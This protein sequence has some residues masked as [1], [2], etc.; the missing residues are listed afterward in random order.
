MKG[1]AMV[2]IDTHTIELAQAG[3]VNAFESIYRSFFGF[4]S[5]VAYRVVGNVQDAQEV[6][7]ETFL[8][9]HRHLKNFRFQSSLKTWVYRITVNTAI[10][11]AKKRSNQRKDQSFDESFF[12][13]LEPDAYRMMEKEE[14]ERRVQQLLG[15]LS[16]DHR[17]VL[18][19]RSLQG[20]SYKEIAD[21]LEIPIN[22]VRTRI[23]RAREA[24]LALKNEVIRDEV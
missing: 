24:L 18:V 6:T 16:L 4:V 23:K 9:M 20:L 7:Q 14:N 1:S 22:T 10:N 3:D 15:F 11:Y 17:A 5:N 13:S 19:L 8:S 2:D 21:T 12:A